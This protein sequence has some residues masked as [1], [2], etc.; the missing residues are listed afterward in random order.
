MEIPDSYVR[1]VIMVS[2]YSEGRWLS[3]ACINWH[4]LDC[5]IEK[6]E[7]Q[8]HEFFGPAERKELFSQLGVEQ[9]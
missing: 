1:G 6:C 9:Q 8:C 4:H 7:C 3:V 5:R 2:D